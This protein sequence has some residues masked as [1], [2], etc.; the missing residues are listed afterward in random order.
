MRGAGDAWFIIGI[1]AFIFVL[2]LT[3]GGPTRPISFAGPYITPLTTNT[4]LQVGYG[5]DISVG[6][7]GSGGGYWSVRSVLG[8]FEGSLNDVGSYGP[9]SPHV[10]DIV[11]A[12]GAGGP[13][14]TDEDR[15]YVTLRSKSD[16]TVNITGWRLV[17][18]KS[19]AQAT[20]GQGAQLARLGAMSAVLLAPG[21]E[22]VIT[23]G[24]SPVD[25]SFRENSCIGYV[26]GADNLTPSLSRNSCPAPLDE[27][28]TYYNGTAA[29]YNDCREHVQDISRCST[30]DAPREASRS[31]RDFIE[32]RLNYSACVQAHQFDTDFYGDTW[33]V[34]L[35]RSEE[36]WR[37]DNE[38]IRLV[39]SAGKTVDVYAY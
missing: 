7:G 21:D 38:I 9:I 26:S 15:E 5:D 11:I 31:C 22:A 27:L 20:I 14:A 37:S 10:D 23:T 4:D 39:D 28:G 16:A 13:S 18:N 19:G 32:T 25:G 30:P 24:G 29:D 17:S 3:T 8:R 2:W 1:F 33:R 6:G 12:S 36:L 34:F 35:E